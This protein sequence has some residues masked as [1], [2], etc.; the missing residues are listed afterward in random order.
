MDSLVSEQENSI[1]NL[2]PVGVGISD[3]QGNLLF[4]NTAMLA[5]GGYS[6]EEMQK[7][8]N[9]AAL[10]YDP[11]ARTKVLSLAK[12]QGYVNGCEVEFKRRD[13]S[14]YS[15]LLSLRMIRYKEAPAW[16]AIVEDITKKKSLEVSEEKR[17][18]DL[19]NTKLAMIN[20]LEDLD[21]E[22]AVLEQERKKDDALLVSIGDGVVVTDELGHI[23]FVNKAFE[24]LTGWSLL[25]VAGKLM[26]DILPKY[27]EKDG[28]IEHAE[29]SVTK[30]LEGKVAR[31]SMSTLNRSHYYKKKDGSK[32][33]IVGVVTPIVVNDAIAGAVQV[34]RDV[35]LEKE[36]DTMKD[37]FV[38]IASH[39]L[40]TPLTAIDGLVS[41]ILDGEYGHVGENLSQPL[42]DI[43]TSSE[44]LIRLVN[45]LLN[46]S[47]LRAG[48]LQYNL[49][50]FSIS[51]IVHKVVELLAQM[52]EEKGFYLKIASDLEVNVFADSDKVE[53]ILNNLIGNSLK[54]TD[55]GGAVVNVEELPDLIKVSI[56]DTGIGI[57]KDAQG[58]LFGRFQQIG[59]SG[60]RPQGTGLGLHIS[61]EMVRRMG[62]DLVL[63][64]SEPGKGSTFTFTLPKVGGPLAEKIREEIILEARM[65]PDQ[66]S[67]IMG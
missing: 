7:I 16:L 29:R 31:G 61:R 12:S 41:M 44:R 1:L 38:S 8:D 13:G 25:E 19:E 30:V 28:L 2:L 11:E 46:L 37:E 36:I 27:D 33:P 24:D 62:G 3:M 66:K 65:H 22:K 6:R 58:Q 9:V 21:A 5:S 18:G 45:D 43:S 54:F 17:T 53:Q 56:V 64:N 50:D 52:F 15:T 49:T 10:Y 57:E 51:A 63:E 20:L 26:V 48:R 4:Y 47:R 34:F 59:T 60:N 32:M 35:T 67:D 55:K 14:P 42:K 39:E 23:T 40:R